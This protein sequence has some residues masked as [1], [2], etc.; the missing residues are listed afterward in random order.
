MPPFVF[1]KL[2]W[3]ANKE[4]E[5]CSLY[6]T[7]KYLKVRLKWAHTYGWR[8]IP[9]HKSEDRRIFKPIFDALECFCWEFLK[10]CSLKRVIQNCK[11]ASCEPASCK[12]ANCELNN[13]R[14]VSC[15]SSNLQVVS[16]N[17][18]KLYVASCGSVSVWV[19]YCCADIV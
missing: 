2:P 17:S 14:I 15:E 12:S 8:D 19:A 18:T 6:N 1:S 5:I 10:Y 4:I 7:H 13:F 9:F 16:C 3:F 11:P